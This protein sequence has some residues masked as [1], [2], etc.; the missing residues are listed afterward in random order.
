MRAVPKTGSKALLA[1]CAARD[2]LVFAAFLLLTLLMT[3]PWARHLRDTA[4]DWGDPYLNSWI[5]WWDFHQ[6]FHDPLNLF[7]GNI[8]FPYRYTLAFSEH[9]YGIA[10]PLFPLFALGLR[11]LT[12]QGI[13]TL[14]G[15][16]LSGF[17]AFRLART[18]TGSPGAGWVAGIAFAF[19]PYRFHQLPHVNYVFAAW[20]PLTLEALVLFLRKPDRRRT[21]W[22]GAAVFLSGLSVIHWFVLSLV[23]L[24]LT[25]LFLAVRYGRDLVRDLL[26][27]A[28]PALAAAG[29]LLLPFLIPYARVSKL[30]GMVR[31]ED[32]T[33]SWSA[34]PHHWLTSDPRSRL[35]RGLGENPAPGELCLFPGLLLILLPAAGLL[36]VR[37]DED[38]A[39]VPAAPPPAAPPNPRLL[40]ALDVLSVAA[41]TVALLASNVEPFRLSVFGREVLKASNPGRALVLLALLLLARWLLAWPRA[42]FWVRNRNLAESLRN[43]TRS[44]VIGV[45]LIC[46]GAGFLGSLGLRFVFHRTLYELVP[47][48]RSIRVPARWSMVA[49]LGLALL[50]GAGALALAEA[51]SRRR[52]GS[53]PAGAA[54]FLA[55]SLALLFEQRVA[56][57]EL[58]RGKADPDGLTRKIAT[59]EMAGGLLELPSSHEIHGNYE[60]VLRAADHAKPLVNGVSGFNLPIV[61]KIEEL[62]RERPIPDEFLDLLE[63]IPVSYLTVRESWL[64]PA[65][66]AALRDLL[67]RGQDTGRIRYVGRFDRTAR[68]DLWAVTKT[69]PGAVTE[70]PVPWRFTGKL[71]PLAQIPEGRRRDDLL[72]GSLDDP[73]ENAVV[74]GPL[75]V[76]GW[77]RIPGEDLE[78]RILIDGEERGG[79]AIRRVPRPDVCAVIPGMGECATAGYEARFDPAPDDDDRHEVTVIFFSRDGRYRVYPPSPI[80]WTP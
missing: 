73:A 55:A 58:F 56:P 76:R 34:K 17:G 77:A 51:W 80:R 21:A 36:L 3:W 14:L 52:G 44:D 16:A 67:Q 6:T 79:N 31:N 63:S 59:L 5:L 60:F 78:V 54:V 48:F 29:I 13:A 50:A 35:W 71:G 11:P 75:L 66:R 20:I 32:E 8:F 43:R 70:M 38:E 69:E 33:F 72:S 7:H 12:A 28:A 27:K 1:R 23:P 10:L 61:V 4:S 74:T 65:Q 30:Y 22:L 45:G 57:L 25:G 49:D 46:F 41:A 9:N 40:L 68:G 15:F 2:T 62:T 19:V 37:R 47:L 24:V 53:R 39:A 26:P 18:L 64:T 42:F